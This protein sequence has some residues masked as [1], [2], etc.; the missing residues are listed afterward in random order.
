MEQPAAEL[1]LGYVEAGGGTIA[2]IGS[3]PGALHFGGDRR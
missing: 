3:S 1:D 2:A